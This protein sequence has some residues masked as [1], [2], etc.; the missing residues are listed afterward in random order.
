MVGL[1]RFQEHFAAFTDQYVL[2]G[3]TAT[4]LVLDEQGLEEVACME[5][6]GMQGLPTEHK[7]HVLAKVFPAI[8]AGYSCYH[9]HNTAHRSLA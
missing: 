3:G 1:E 9:L 2:I 5:P 6:C 4:Q 7:Q 8:L